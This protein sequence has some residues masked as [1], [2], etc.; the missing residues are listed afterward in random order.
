M[1][2]EP[3]R[4]SNDSIRST[5]WDDEDMRELV[6]FFV[7]DLG[8]RV[9]DLTRAWEQANAEQ[10]RIFAH[11]LKGAAPGYGFDGIG[12]AAGRLETALS[13]LAAADD[14]SASEAEFRTLLDLC[15]RAVIGS[16]NQ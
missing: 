1:G 16:P 4:R 6:E 15:R 2:T 13:S 5:F 8:A 3:N 12:N 10:I 9:D 7:A 14:L 11:Q